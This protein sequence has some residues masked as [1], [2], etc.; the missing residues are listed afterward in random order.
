MA[1][2]ISRA[3]NKKQGSRR[4]TSKQIAHLILAFSCQI[5]EVL[6]AGSIRG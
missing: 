2:L 1:S 4:L 6:Q 3:F 5:A